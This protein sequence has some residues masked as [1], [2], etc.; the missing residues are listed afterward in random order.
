MHKESSACYVLPRPASR[1]I[2][3]T[4]VVPLLNNT[5]FIGLAIFLFHA[6][7]S[8]DSF[9]L[10]LSLRSAIHFWKLV[11]C[12]HD[13]TEFSVSCL[14]VV[15]PIWTLHFNSCEKFLTKVLLFTEEHFKLYSLP[16][17]SMNLFLIFLYVCYI[18]HH[19]I[20]VKCMPIRCNFIFICNSSNRITDKSVLLFYFLY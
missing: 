4:I 17:F 3:G 1:Y 5:F 12:T 8:L 6:V 11:S 13:K 2:S 15:R 20:S 16:S 19:A 9:Y 7:C 14:R 10:F 18:L